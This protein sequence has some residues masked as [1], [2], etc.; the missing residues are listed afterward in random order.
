VLRIK[1]RFPRD[2]GAV[3]DGEYLDRLPRSG[4]T[5]GTDRDHGG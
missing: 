2:H 1:L 3:A 4:S 5:G